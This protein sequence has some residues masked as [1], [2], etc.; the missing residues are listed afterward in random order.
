MRKSMVIM[1]CIVSG[2]I[3]GLAQ[4]GFAKGTKP[5]FDPAVLQ[6]SDTK[7]IAGKLLDQA[8]VLA[9]DGSWERIAVG[10]VWYLG[11][12]KA[13]GQQI[14]DGVTGGKKVADS[15]WF[16]IARVYAQAKEWE[17]ADAAFGKALAL[18]PEDND[19][20]VEHASYMNLHGDRAKAEAVFAK[21][22]AAQPDRMYHYTNAAGSYL[23]VIP[24]D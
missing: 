14:F 10:R 20:R 23:G 5:T 6:G 1:L 21:V 22:I 11:G 2:V 16:R 13:K 12:D 4:R 18:D 8:L 19:G 15:D 3:G 24:E 9:G 7:A 17:K